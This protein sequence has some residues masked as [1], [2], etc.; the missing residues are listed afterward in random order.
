MVAL[1]RSRTRP[2][3]RVPHVCHLRVSIIPVTSLLVIATETD[4]TVFAP[5]PPV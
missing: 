2:R 5:G 1:A 3:V 4:G